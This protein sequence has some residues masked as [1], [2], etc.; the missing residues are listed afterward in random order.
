MT[1]AELLLRIRGDSS[2]AENALARTDRRSRD[3]SRNVGGIGSKLAG[4]GKVAAVGLGVMGGAAVLAGGKALK[5][6]GEAEAVGAQTAAAI[7]STGGAANVSAG[8]VGEL[9]ATL[10]KLTAFEDEAIASSSNLLLTFTNIKNEVGAGN[11]IFN[12]ATGTILDMSQALGQDTKSSAIQLGKALNDPIKGITALSRVGV[13]FTEQQ[14]KQ[15]KALA[16][17]GDLLGAQKIILGELGKEFGGSAKAFAQTGAGALQ[18]FQNEMGNVMEELG[19]TLAPVLREVLTA[20]KPLLPVL[21]K[22]LVGAV[23][24]VAPVIGVVAKALADLLPKVMPIIEALAG[25]LVPILKALLPAIVPIV[26]A[27]ATGLTEALVA[28]TPGLVELAKTIGALL[29]ALVP[30]LPPIFKLV[31]ALLTL[32]SKV[33]KPFHGFLRAVFVPVIEL[34]AK[35][36]SKVFGFIAGIFTDFGGS[37]GKVRDVVGNALG[38][39]G[40]FFSNIGGAIADVVLNM[41]EKIIGFKDKVFEKLG[42][43]RDFFKELPGK[44]LGFLR[45][46]PGKMLQMGKDIIQGLVDGIKAA[47]GK[48]VDAVKGAVGGAIDK[49]GELIGWGSP[50]KLFIRMG[51]DIVQGLA[52]GLEGNDRVLLSSMQALARLVKDAPLDSLVAVI[53]SMPD[54]IRLE[55]MPKMFGLLRNRLHETGLAIAE[56]F[57]IVKQ[58]FLS[59]T[60]AVA[61]GMNAAVSV[62]GRFAGAVTDAW[63]DGTRT[64]WA[65]QQSFITDMNSVVKQINKMDDAARKAYVKSMGP[66]F[67][68]ALKKAG[69]V[70][71]EDFSIVPSKFYSKTS[72]GQAGSKVATSL[73]MIGSGGRGPTT[74]YIN[75]GGI[76]EAKDG[77]DT[78]QE[79][80]RAV[81]KWEAANGPVFTNPGR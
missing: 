62:V 75:V 77:Y 81:K 31:A 55:V 37:V 14:K 76:T 16:E 56:D 41:R 28:A 38:A 51:K 7:K 22:A 80:I 1:A 26:D 78:A 60:N 45:E 42:Q 6:F 74:V 40:R 46:L 9:A 3:L 63:F 69:Y 15:I 4:A 64:L 50:A 20:V 72:K 13:S 54:K 29:V 48:V 35:I 34:L 44:I 59:D 25:A 18:Q 70:L 57:T 24:A 61:S 43:I 65:S 52:L 47:P 39:V 30:I 10:S 67:R 68:D 53:N 8:D 49:A 32:W 17:S 23:K 58:K 27:L 71:A 2:S 33:M 11:D 19:G 21:G 66:G 12:Q 36:V 5:A 73:P 79:V